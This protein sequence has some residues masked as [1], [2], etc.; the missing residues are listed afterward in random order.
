MLSYSKT[1]KVKGEFSIV[2]VLQLDSQVQLY[3]WIILSVRLCFQDSW[4]Q[5]L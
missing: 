5:F 1:F 2:P 3:A 4:P